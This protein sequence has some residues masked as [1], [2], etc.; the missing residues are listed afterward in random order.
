M[1]VL[2]TDGNERSALAV[3]RALGRQGLQVVIG[4]EHEHSLASASKYCWRSFSY[5][6]PYT[7][8]QGFLWKI[9]DTIKQLQIDMVF[10]ISDTTMLLIGQH[11][12]EFEAYSLLPIPSAEVFESFSNKYYLMQTAAG[13]EIPIPDTIFIP[14]GHWEA[15][16][17]SIRRFPVVVKP[18][19]SLVYLNDHLHKTK[20]H[21]ATNTE[22]LRRLYSD[23]DYLQ[24]PSLIQR[25]VEGEGQGIFAIMNKGKPVTLFA[26][27]RLREKPPSGGVSVLR[28]SIPLPQPMTDYAL[29][30][31]QHANWHGVAMVEFKVDRQTGVPLLMEVNGRFWG[32]LQLAVDAGL[33]FPYLLYQMAIGEKPRPPAEGYRTGVKSRWLLGDLDHLLLRLFKSD[34]ELS[35][36]PNSPARLT[37]L[38]EFCRFYQKDMYYEIL[39]FDDL[40][41]FAYE[42][43]Q[44]V[45][46]LRSEGR[47]NHDVGIQGSS[48]VHKELVSTVNRN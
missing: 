48:S 1:N 24:Q 7:D 32:S 4:A 6:S 38:L 44:Y 18:G 28:E 34:A 43:R 37:T 19:R 11:Q 45:R 23:V 26:H 10:P 20:V 46:N 13:L 14:D 33:N 21:Y 5:P 12:Q 9:L 17:S 40:K 36:P 42:L 31:L 29:R 15:E 3:T 2:V 27:R 25:R 8:M 47:G 35:L 30:L 16:L 41:P 39:R 22:E